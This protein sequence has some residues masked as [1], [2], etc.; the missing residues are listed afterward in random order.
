MV[1]ILRV[2]RGRPADEP[3]SGLQIGGG[4]GGRGGGGVAWRSLVGLMVNAVYGGRVDSVY[5][6]RVSGGAR[7][8]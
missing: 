3:G 5:D 6:A 2:L 7:L 1:E 4:G 8:Q